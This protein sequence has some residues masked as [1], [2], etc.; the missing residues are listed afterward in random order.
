M[1][2]D[3]FINLSAEDLYSELKYYN[4]Y[5]IYNMSYPP[6]GLDIKRREIERGV[7]IERLRH[8]NANKRRVE[9]K[10]KRQAIII[11]NGYMRGGHVMICT[12]FFD[13]SLLYNSSG[14]LC[15]IRKYSFLK[16]SIDESY[17]LG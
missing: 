2:I 7:P 1:T 16:N 11:S 15:G 12:G 14:G 8:L 9:K 3:K 17:F 13:V 4:F 5:N 6:F 10:R